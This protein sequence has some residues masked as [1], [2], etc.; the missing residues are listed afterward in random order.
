M[1]FIAVRR[2]CGVNN[3]VHIIGI[4]FVFGLDRT[5]QSKVIVMVVCG[6]SLATNR[7]KVGELMYAL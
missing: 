4:M 5:L 7:N 1:W 3:A 6:V 2:L